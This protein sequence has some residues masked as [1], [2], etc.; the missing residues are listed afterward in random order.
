MMTAI[1]KVQQDALSNSARRY[2][3]TAG[4]LLRHSMIASNSGPAFIVGQ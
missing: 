4:V 1:G 3:G 2:F